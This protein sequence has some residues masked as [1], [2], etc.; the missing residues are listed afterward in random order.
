MPDLISVIVPAHNAE[1]TIGGCLDALCRQTLARDRYEILVIDDASVDAT[2]DRAK[3]GA[4]R[5]I[6]LEKNKGP[7]G[8]RNAGARDAKGDLLVF[9]DADCE[10]EERFLETLT[11]PLCDPDLDGTKG[12]YLTRQTRTTARFVQLEYEDRYRRMARF[13]EID[14]VDTYAAC[15]RRSCF[16]RV[17]GFD[18]RLR[19]CEDQ[20]LSFRLTKSGAKLRFIPE[21]RTY[22]RHEDRL[23]G[24]L[25][26]KYKIAWW[27]VAVLRRHPDKISKDTHTPQTLKAEMVAAFAVLG[28]VLA[29]PLLALWHSSA[30][31]IAVVCA[32][33]VAFLALSLPFAW[34][35]F[36]KDPGVGLVAP[37]YLFLRDLALGAGLA[38]GMLRAPRIGPTD[39]GVRGRTT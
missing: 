3:D 29:A 30:L 1:A 24:Y 19:I 18:D 13:P 5:T 37:A 36:R 4:D 34:R 33:L 31:A 9:T 35:A 14:F 11:S 39:E 26:K 20:D 17:N 6:Q 16:E 21:A 23:L 25:A 7:A 10:P 22:H 15:V 32:P 8:A 38:A 12:T 2:C 28:A 27:K